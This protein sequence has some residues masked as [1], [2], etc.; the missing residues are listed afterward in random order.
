MKVFYYV[1][2][3][4]CTIFFSACDL[5]SDERVTFVEQE[6]KIDILVDGQVFTSY[7]T[8]SQYLG[9]SVT[10]PI[11]FPVFTPSGIKVNRSF[12]FAEVEG[13]SPDHPHHTGI[14]FTYDEVNESGFWNNTKFP[15]Q[16][17]HLAV[18]EAKGGTIG[19][20]E[21]ESEWISKTSEPLLKEERTMKFIPGDDETAIDFTIKLTALVDKV[22]FGDT[23]EGM[24][25]IRV[26]HQLRENFTGHYLSSN[27]DENE[28]NVWAKR[29]KWMKLA[30]V[31]DS[32]HV[33]IIIMNHPGSTNYPT[34]WHARGYGLFSA[35][36]LGQFA[37]EK[38]RKVENPKPFGLSL[39]KG[40]S[41]LFKFLMIIYDGERT[42]EV[43]EARFAE[44]AK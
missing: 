32:T 4:L 12:P 17:K 25:A 22:E 21:T 2:L 18:H 3:V 5:T 38:A 39:K 27:G 19:V 41:A 15:P 29:A 37:F 8:A 9:Q 28:E 35:N 20:L 24:F 42:P 43:I 40:Q 1:S 33:G 14:F 13:E 36:P 34:F 6:D 16:I 44:Y 7:I 10:K 30:G 26:A 11:L 23:K 31:I